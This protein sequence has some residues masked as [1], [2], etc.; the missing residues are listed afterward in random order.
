MIGARLENLR[1]WLERT[2]NRERWGLPAIPDGPVNA[3]ILRRTLAQAIAERPG[4]L[5]AAKVALKHISVATTEG[6]AARPGGSQRLFLA[7]V[8]EAAAEYHVRLTVEAFHDFQ[9][10]RLPA[11]PGA[12]SLIEAFAL[13]D[14]E[15]KEAARTD[16]KVLTDDTHLESL[17]RKQAQTLH[18]GAANYCWFR[19]PAKALCLRL[20]GTPNASKPL[21]GMCDS[22]RCPQATHPCHRPVWTGQAAGI[23]VFLE[24]PRV[25]VGER[26]RLLP[27]A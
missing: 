3:R 1:N 24:S 26:K 9:E 15:L 23:T 21:V 11:G 10:D 8:E 6:Y 16:P 17:L 20:A 22:A 27:R 25:P 19:D 12:R 14:A 7:E 18:V 4:G 5:L 2:G 13:V